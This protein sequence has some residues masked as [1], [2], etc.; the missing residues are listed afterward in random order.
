MIGMRLIQLTKIFGCKT[1]AAIFTFSATSQQLSTQI[2]LNQI[3]FYPDAPKVAIITGDVNA[4][5]FYVTSTNL[6]DTFYTGFLGNTKQSQYSKTT[7][8]L[9]DF[10]SLKIPGSYVL[11]IPGTGHSYVFRIAA[12][13]HREVAIA[14]MKSFYFQRVS[15]PLLPQYAGKWHRSA[16]HPDDSVLI[17]SSAATKQR[18]AGTIVPSSG[19]WYDAGDYNKYI[20]NSGITMGT[21]LSLYE[22]FP[23]YTK[24]FHLKIPESGG[25]IPDLL[26]EVLY[27]L[28]WM[29]TMQDPYDGGVHHKCTNASF[30]GMVMPGIT[31][32]PRYLVQ[33]STAAALDF[34]AVTAQAARVFKKFE[35]SLPRLADSCLSASEKAWL[36]A[37]ANPK[38]LY[39]QDEM[40]KTHKPE[41]TTGAYGDR[42][43]AD[44]WLWA[45]AELFV[46]TKKQAYFNSVQ[47]QMKLRFSVPGWSNVA[48][49]GYYSLN[50]FSNSL[51]AYTRTTTAAMKDSI[52]LKADELISNRSKNAFDV[53]MGQTERDFVW[54]SN[55]VAANQGI[56]LLYAYAATKNR[57]Y[58]DHALT[59]LDYI[60]G[61]N[62]TGFS[63]LT[64]YGSK[65]PMHIHHRPSEA[66]GIIEPVPGLLSGGPN[67]GRQDKCEYPETDTEIAFVDHV[68]SYASNEIAI[69]WNA[70]FVY[71]ATAVEALQKK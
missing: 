51:P 63:F 27:N 59:N 49:L 43:I 18:P 44:E 23:E 21:L 57:K 52:V 25:R 69:N 55:A 47:E 48:A 20:V 56:L 29:L 39:D 3:G 26:H 22:D 16:G 10:S 1:F 31:K 42:N 30:D 12:N 38:I 61:R 71:L 11:L 8:R 53:I 17:H 24:T 15:M 5:A 34:A 19:G 41:I 60:L 35:T 50:R 54:G 64:G 13:V 7:T 40:N 4:T 45:A 68:C 36:W 62:A 32:E 2:K 65:T 28:R 58:I 37:K 70:P 9:A 46:T 6:R 14:S 33:K 66:D 67:P